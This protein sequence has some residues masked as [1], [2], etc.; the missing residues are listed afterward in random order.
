VAIF[1]V[2]DGV[3][4]PEPGLAGLLLGFGMLGLRRRR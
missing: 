3:V 2:F 4:I 1:D